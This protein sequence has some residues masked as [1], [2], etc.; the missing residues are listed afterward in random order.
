MSA[1]ARALFLASL[2]A[3][4]L[5]AG[6]SA[7]AAPP[8]GPGAF[9]GPDEPL[10]PGPGDGPDEEVIPEQEPTPPTPAVEVSPASVA[11]GDDGTVDLVF[12]VDFGAPC[13][14]LMNL[15]Y[16][17]VPWGEDAAT[18]DV[19]FEP[20]EGQ[21]LQIPA[22]ITSTWI[23]VPVF[24][25]LL[26]ELDEEVAVWVTD[27][28]GCDALPGGFAQGAL[29]TIEDDDVQVVS[30]D[31]V[32]VIEGHVG[33]TDLTFT[34]ALD[35]PALIDYSVNVDWGPS[36]AT[37]DVDFVADLPDFFIF[38]E[39][40][41]SQT[42]TIEVAGDIEVEDDEILTVSLHGGSFGLEIGNA[43]GIGTILDDDAP[44]DPGEEPVDP[45]DDGPSTPPDEP[46]VAGASTQRG[47]LPR[48]GAVLLGLGSLGC[49]LVVIGRLLTAAALRVTQQR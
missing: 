8:P 9:A 26:P 2:L 25:D 7:H 16:D 48:T 40:T 23:T 30:I 29:G 45:G 37:P 19:D 27:V 47:A 13:D 41:E 44:A 5:L 17:V 34:V 20:V 11:E 14:Q 18:E 39:G 22:G 15:H 10:E 43:N 49:G 24:G 4:V 21:L 31:D 32:E 3:S 1:T 6:S 28:S 46:Q 38:L 36:T 35:G 12:A 42:V 33:T